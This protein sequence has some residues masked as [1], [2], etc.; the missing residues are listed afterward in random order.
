M[1]VN[2]HVHMVQR[3]HTAPWQVLAG[4]QLGL[5]DLSGPVA[6]VNGGDAWHAGHLSFMS[7]VSG[8]VRGA[9]RL[10]GIDAAGGKGLRA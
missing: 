8:G 9:G 7:F 1:H 6:A 10:D 2:Q 3:P 4:Y 5:P